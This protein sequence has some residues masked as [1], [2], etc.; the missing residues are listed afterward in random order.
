MSEKLEIRQFTES[1]E[2]QK[3]F[4]DFYTI[5]LK[6]KLIAGYAS[7][8]ECL[9]KIIRRFEHMVDYNVPHGKKL[10]GLCVYES[11]LNLIENEK[12]KVDTKL[13]EQAKAIGWCVEFVSFCGIITNYKVFDFYFCM[14]I[15]IQLQASFLVADDI[16]D[17]S[18]YRRGQPCWYLTVII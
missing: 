2:K 7:D 9:D 18:T 15:I 11:F 12:E 6:P 13:I 14:L 1:T 5:T 4:D 16:M 10:R 17:N 3:A 8:P